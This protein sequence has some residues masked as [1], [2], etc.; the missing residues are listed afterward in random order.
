[1]MVML[2]VDETI[3]TLPPFFHRVVNGFT[4]RL[5]PSLLRAGR[6]VN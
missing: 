2:R 1:M 6:S 4:V 3:V 5:V